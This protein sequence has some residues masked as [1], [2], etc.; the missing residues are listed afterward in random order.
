MDRVEEAAQYHEF[1]LFECPRC[2]TELSI[3]EGEPCSNCGGDG[4]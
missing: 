3:V 1:R 4:R 2:G